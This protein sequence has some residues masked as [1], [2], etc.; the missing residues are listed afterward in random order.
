LK[1]GGTLVIGDKRVP[2][3][4]SCFNFKLSKS[5]FL[6]K[7]GVRKENFDSMYLDAK[8]QGFTLEEISLLFKEAGLA[9]IQVI[10]WPRFYLI[11]TG[12]KLKGNG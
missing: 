2:E 6:K 12:T 3:D 4:R 7:Y 10:S 11:C 1:K 9:K 5:D 8:Q